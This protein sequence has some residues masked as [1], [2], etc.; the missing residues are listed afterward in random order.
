M[1]LHEMRKGLLVPPV[2]PEMENTSPSVPV[3]THERKKKSCCWRCCCRTRTRQVC[4][5]F[6]GLSSFLSFLVAFYGVW[7]TVRSHIHEGSQQMPWVPLQPPPSQQACIRQPPHS[8]TKPFMVMNWTSISSRNVTLCIR[9]EG[10]T[11]TMSAIHPQNERHLRI[12]RRGQPPVETTPP[13]LQIAHGPVPS[14]P[15]NQAILIFLV[16]DGSINGLFPDC[17]YDYEAIFPWSDAQQPPLKASIRVHLPKSGLCGNA[18]DLTS[19]SEVNVAEVMTASITSCWSTLFSPECI[20]ENLRTGLRV[21]SPC[22]KCWTSLAMCTLNQCFGVCGPMS[23]GEAC[24]DCA[25]S[26]CYPS[27]AG[28]PR[29]FLPVS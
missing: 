24:Q 20:Q 2:I 7:Y 13:W 25:L 14:Q 21:S 23:H 15:K 9:I 1:T 17:L 16:D 5:V 18:A 3:V 26:K 4:W 22:A 28:I 19:L 29:Q 11:P 10:L 8:G 12:Q 27:C 6:L